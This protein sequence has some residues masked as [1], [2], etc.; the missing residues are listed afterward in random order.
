MMG[1]FIKENFFEIFFSGLIGNIAEVFE[2]RN[3]LM[4]NAYLEIFW[5]LFF[6]C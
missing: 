2:L 1:I 4:T 6:F 5:F 3:Q